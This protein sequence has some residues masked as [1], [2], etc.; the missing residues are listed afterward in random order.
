MDEPP[1]YTVLAILSDP[2]SIYILIALLVVTAG[3]SFFLSGS[4]GAF[5]ALSPADIKK[6][7]QSRN[8]DKRTVASIMQEPQTLARIVT[9]FQFFVRILFIALSASTVLWVEGNLFLQVLMAIVLLALIL[10]SEILSRSLGKKNSKKWA[11]S[12]ISFWSFIVRLLRPFHSF[13]GKIDQ[14]FDQKEKPVSD[15]EL[16]KVLELTTEG[17][18]DEDDK[19]ILRSVVN[20]ETLTVKQVMR[21]RREISAVQRELKFRELLKVVMESGYSRLPVYGNSLDK[22]EGTLY[23]KDLLPFIEKDDSFQ[24]HALIRPSFDVPEHRKIDA[25][26]KDFQERRVLLA[27]VKDAHGKTSGLITLAD[28]VEIIIGDFTGDADGSEKTL[29]QI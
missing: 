4:E 28:I 5:F 8:R 2:D 18:S 26:L 7:E 17:K 6:F 20:F 9:L 3:C 21:H 29:N 14:H 24:W 12:T 23:T 13:A 25:L 27:I 1:G 19:D 22:T 10:T 16:E 11:A 15:E